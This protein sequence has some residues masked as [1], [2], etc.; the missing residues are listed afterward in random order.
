M[1]A[2]NVEIVT[3]ES[4]WRQVLLDLAIRAWS[5]VFPKMESDVPGFVYESFYPQG[6]EARQRSDL[7][8]VLDDE[9]ENVDV[10]MIEGRPV[11]WICTRLHLEDSMGEV[12][13]LVVDPSRQRTGIGAALL[14]HA[15]R[16]ALDSGMRMM[17]VET[18]E[19][20]GH[21][22]ARSLYEREGFVRWPVARYF[23]ELPDEQ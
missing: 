10:A 16:R 11:G 14:D 1:S 7:A 17:M 3:Y 12:Y 5:P 2:K 15:D 6:W 13:V 18:G 21:A 9:P 23:K 20:S 4:A 8:S 19:D 22:P